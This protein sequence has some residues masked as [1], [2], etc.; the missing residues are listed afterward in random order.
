MFFKSGFDIVLFWILDDEERNIVERV[1]EEGSSKVGF[2]GECLLFWHIVPVSK[3]AVGMDFDSAIPTF[4]HPAQL[5]LITSLH[6]WHLH[7]PEKRLC[8]HCSYHPEH[9]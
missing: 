4:A 7:T 9:C 6:C 1:L 2:H 5:C 8:S 3:V